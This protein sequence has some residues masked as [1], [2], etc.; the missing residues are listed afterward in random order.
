MDDAKLDTIRADNPHSV[1]DCCNRMFAEWLN[2]NPT[3]SWK[4]IFTAIERA[5][6]WPASLLAG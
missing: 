5:V 3:A 1:E 6:K 4:D 2:R